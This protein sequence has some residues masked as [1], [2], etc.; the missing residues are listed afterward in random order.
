MDQSDLRG[1]T[2]GSHADKAASRQRYP[3]SVTV[4]SRTRPERVP[5]FHKEDAMGD[6]FA[7]DEDPGN[8]DAVVVGA[9]FAGLYM[10]YRLR[11]LGLRTRVFE[12]GSDVG[13]TWY[14]NRYPGAR[15]DS[16]SMDYSFSFSDEL[17]QEWEWTSRYPDQAEIMRYLRHVAERFDLRRDIQ[18]DT[19]VTTA[20][21][22]EASQ[23]WTVATDRGDRLTAKYVVMATGCLSA[24]QVPQITGLETFQ[25]D[26]YHT[27]SWPHEGVDFSGKSVGVVGTGSSGIQAI[28]VI[29]GQA[30]HLYVFQ[31]TPNFSLP[32]RNGPLDPEQVRELK[33]RYVEYRQEIRYSR[34]G[35]GV[36]APTQS[37][38][39]VTPEERE[40]AYEASWARG[41]IGFGSTFTEMTINKAANDIAAEFVRSK[42][43]ETV[44]DPVVA[45][46]LCPYSY[47]I[48]TKRVC[49]DTNY[50][51]T[52]NR[53]NVTLVDLRKAPLEEVI[54]GGLRTRDA[55]YDL[56][57]IVFATG[58]NAMTGALL[59]IDIRG[60]GGQSLRDKWAAGPRAYLGISIAGFP[61]LFTITGPGSPSVLTNMP[62]AIE[63]HVEWVADCIAHLEERSIATIEPTS[64]AE[65]AWV[66][67]VSELGNAT[68][69]PLANSWYMGA[70]VPGKPRVFMPYVGGLGVY[71]RHCEQ[72]AANG[73]EGFALTAR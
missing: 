6:Q 24:Q 36:P 51:E 42:I 15:C 54:P 38:L 18:F 3:T 73:Y 23:C 9:G 56:D 20:H 41:G 55:T 49:L 45:E 70:N 67:H 52:Y 33:A 62:V 64:A 68:L 35:S 66:E 10:L 28:P 44:H 12:M 2:T 17:L 39:E 31:R 13:G 50:Y 72:I 14:W 29:A 37:A 48:G 19:R 16:D 21:F 25:G 30:R 40:R 71:S 8:L 53:P 5:P 60:R 26:W 7:P 34:G 27:G 58:Y 63:Q 43:R 69:F 46:A 65:D 22:D 47:P 1:R 59:A 61:N 4:S 57:I 11:E 32:A